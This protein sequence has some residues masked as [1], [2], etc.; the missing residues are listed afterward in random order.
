MATRGAKPKPVAL[1]L[2][3]GTHRNARHGTQDA[4]REAVESVEKL[5][6]KLAMPKGLK[7]K[8]RTAW[9]DWIAPASWLDKFKAPAAITF[10]Q[11][12]AEKERAPAMFPA[13]KL[14]QLRGLMNELGLTDE[15]NRGAVDGEDTDEFFGD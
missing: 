10:C 9:L 6:G 2:V 7:G 1:R 11:L 5:V 15:R 3:D 8:E 4:A 12:W 14:G 13:A